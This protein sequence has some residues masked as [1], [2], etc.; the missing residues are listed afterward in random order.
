MP[1][2]PQGY[3]N[4]FVDDPSIPDMNTICIRISITKSSLKNLFYI[5]EQ[6]NY[7]SL[8]VAI[9]QMIDRKAAGLRNAQ[10]KSSEKKEHQSANISMPSNTFIDTGI[11]PR[12]LRQ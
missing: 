8:S 3:L 11:Q 12:D 5:K 6:Y 1:D 7:G 4:K 10:K 9:R 2:V